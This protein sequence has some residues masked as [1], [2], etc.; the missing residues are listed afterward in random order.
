[1]KTLIRYS[2]TTALG[3]LLLVTPAL[4]GCDGTS[5]EAKKAK[6][7]EL[8]AGYF[9]KGQYNEALLEYKN[10]AQVDPQDADAHYRL[11]LT[12]LKLGGIPNLQG[13]YAELTRTVELDKTNQEAQLK[14]GQMY[15]LGN[16]PVKAREQAEIVLVSTP[17]NTEGLILRGR[18]LINEKRYQEG[19][20]ELKK[21]VELDP[22]TMQTYIDLA[23]AYFALNDTVAAEKILRQALTLDARSTDIILALADLQTTTGKQDQAEGTYKQALEIAPENEGI[24]LRLAAF[25]QRQ[26]KLADAEAILQKLASIKPQHENAHLHLGDFY[27][28]LGQSEKALASY[29]RATDVN[30]N[31]TLAR[32][33]LIGHYLDTGKTNEAEAK[34]KELLD[35]NNKDLMG[36]YFDARIQLT[37]TKPDEAISLL[38]GVLKDEPQFAGAHYFLG[39]AFLQKHQTAQARGSFAEAVKLNPQL[40]EARTALAQI[41][42]AEGSADLAIEQAQA[43]IQLNPRN[44]QAAIIAGDAYLSKKDLAKSKQ[45]FE[46]IAKVLPKEPIAPYRLGLVAQAEKNDAKALAY[47]EEALTRRPGAIEPIA[48]IAAIK[49]VQGK[50]QEARERVIRQLEAAPKSPLLHNLLGQL[51]LQAKDAG[52][53]EAAFKK[54]IDLDNSLLIAYMNLGRAYHLSGKTDQALKEY[55]IVLAKDP[56]VIQAHMLLG[57]IH[58]SRKEFDK[59]RERY[60]TILKL[61]PQFAPAANN[62]AWDLADR[63]GNLDMALSYAQT[64]RE[65]KPDDPHIADTLGWV[66]YKKNAYL[67]AVGLL[68]EAVEKLPNEPVVHF[69]YG[70]AQQKSG[71]TAGAKKALQ[72]ALKLSENFPGADEARKTIEGL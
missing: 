45:V 34:I 62:L 68:K 16:E 69:H 4:G 48:Q 17:Q 14:L 50:A 49:N 3:C 15:L 25:Y 9:E 55:E 35:K 59:A 37:K 12:Y 61:N 53:A 46:A 29:Q 13:A 67:L 54:A 19:I 71:D 52:Q 38:Q 22:K 2:A 26:N 30:P 7:R 33:K 31:S 5:P 60:Q 57:I 42:L 63:G 70:M 47:F 39:V 10:V 64:A 44:V 28:S 24:Y 6:H 23:R 21:A 40:G 27:T 66:Y 58:E 18:S 41:H 11:A 72:T 32:D 1:M 36:R 56:K 43:A 51:W 65:Q 8:A 20:V